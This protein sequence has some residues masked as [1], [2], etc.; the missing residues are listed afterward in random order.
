MRRSALLAVCLAVFVDMLGFGIILPSLPLHAADLGGGGI[1]VG[2][3]LTVYAAAQFVAAPVLGSLSDRY[4][5][6]RLLLLSLA[7]SAVSL[8][9]TGVAG[10]LAL[11]LLARVVAG[12]FGGATAVGQAYAID[13][14]SP[15]R[16]TRALGLIGG[17]IGLGFVFGPAIGAG[18]AG[19]GLDFAG[20]CFVA[21]GIAVANLVLGLFLLPGPPSRPAGR[22]ER[23]AA[24]SRIAALRAGLRRGQLR[25][26]L[27]AMFGVTF[28]FVGMETT[29]ALLARARFG[30]GPAGLGVVFAGVGVIMVIVQGG[31]VSR[32]SDRFGDAPVAVA[33]AVLL[34]AGLLALP[35]APAAIGYPALGLVAIGQGLLSPTTAALIARN[36]GRNLGGLLGV[37][38]SAAAA[39]RAVGPLVAGLAFE[40]QPAVPYLL[41]TAACLV[42]AA[43]LRT[44]ATAAPPEPP[45][46]AVIP[47]PR[48]PGAGRAELVGR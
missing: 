42:A 48:D 40:L 29:F 33:G 31:L 41:G 22:P 45:P 47:H 27:L 18:L 39:A 4:G 21:A 30:L 34:G 1:W 16:R 3:L 26:V 37:G 9:V 38:Q 43:L 13:L 15:E 17:S 6:R 8:A 10:S 44:V 2:A 23:L 46:A 35:F 5:R 20:T 19:L 11:L 7:G 36:G 28:A 25:P 24:L 32:L 14:S 12:G